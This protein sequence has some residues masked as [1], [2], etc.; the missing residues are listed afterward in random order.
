MRQGSDSGRGK[1][2]FCV[3]DIHTGSGSHLTYSVGV[4]GHFTGE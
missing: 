1:G 2:T 4:E 3:P